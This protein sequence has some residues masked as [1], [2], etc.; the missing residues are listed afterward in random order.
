MR[1]TA[2]EP[3]EESDAGKA[4]ILAE[5][6]FPGAGQADLTDI[7]S[8]TQAYPVLDIPSEVWPGTIERFLTE[9]PNSKAPGPDGIQN[10]VLKMVCPDL[11]EPLAEV[12]SRHLA[13]G[14]L[15]ET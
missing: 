6:F 12:I 14:T 15:P 4:R 13:A 7:A 8:N 5:R 9:M 10:E 11:A 1:R 3:L 2:Q